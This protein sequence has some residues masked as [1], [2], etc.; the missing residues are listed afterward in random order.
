MD[1]EYIA[2]CSLIMSHS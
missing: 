1:A 2:E